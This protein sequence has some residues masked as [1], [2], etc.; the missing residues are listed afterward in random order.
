ML[1]RV[2][3][4]GRIFF[5]YVCPCVRPPAFRGLTDTDVSDGEKKEREEEGGKE[6]REGGQGFT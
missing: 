6:G 3:L 5:L 1:G 4:V 2:Q